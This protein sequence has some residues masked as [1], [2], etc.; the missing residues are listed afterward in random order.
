VSEVVHGLHSD[1]RV[2]VLPS[3]KRRS[4]R[5]AGTQ[6]GAAAY[7]PTGSIGVR[8]AAFPCTTWKRRIALWYRLQIGIEDPVFR[9]TA[10][11]TPFRQPR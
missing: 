10:L 1:D 2:P 8:L 9:V 7:V 11:V 4:K 3:A 6:S 5:A